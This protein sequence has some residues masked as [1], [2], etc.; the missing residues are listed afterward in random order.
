MAR[1]A[2]LYFPGFSV[3]VMHRGINRQPIF[4]DDNDRQRFLAFLEA[5]MAR[6][7]VAVHVFALM[8]NHYHLLVTPSG[9]QA[10]ARAMRGLGIRYTLYYN[11]K[12]D[13][14]GTL[15]TGRYR[16]IPIGD[17]HYW[18]ACLR[19]I[20]LNP[21]R[22]KLVVG[23]EDYQW[24]TYRTYA[25]GEPQ[26]W[27]AQHDLCVALGA[28]VEERQMAYRALCDQPLTDADLLRQ[29]LGREDFLANPSNDTASNNAALSAAF[30]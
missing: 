19:Y 18:L 27:I 8:P 9:E 4:G 13:R 28:N 30:G 1:R 24:S 26:R 21:V 16:G 17:E 20:E 29:R 12:Y 7:G 3:H 2:R 15:W 6:Y 23:P 11:R 5:A 25:F 10:L 14:I 22:A